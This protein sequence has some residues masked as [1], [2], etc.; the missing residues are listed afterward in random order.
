MKDSPLA[1][2]MGGMGMGG[3]PGQMPKLNLEDMIHNM[4]GNVMKDLPEQEKATFD[5]MMDTI[6]PVLKKVDNI[7]KNSETLSKE[8][9]LAK[10]NDAKKALK[11]IVP[12]LEHKM[13]D[14]LTSIPEED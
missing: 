14:A 2:L 5:S 7:H 10:T 6:N 12:E 1:G 13:E 3:K 8:E 4:F 9:L 11:N